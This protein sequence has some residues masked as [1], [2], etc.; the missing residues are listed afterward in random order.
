MDM[1]F[2]KL[3]ELVIDREAWHAAVHG[4]AK[5]R[6]K[7]RDICIYIYYISQI[8]FI[9][10]SYL[11]SF[12]I[13]LHSP[14][15]LFNRRTSGAPQIALLLQNQTLAHAPVCSKAHLLTLVAIV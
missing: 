7:L 5:S 3:Q 8:F 6:T 11:E 4:I 12:K 14:S 13:I 1:S 9:V 15:L 2:S 10:L